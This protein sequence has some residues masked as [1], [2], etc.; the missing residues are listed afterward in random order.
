MWCNMCKY[1][2]EATRKGKCSQCGGQI[3]LTDRP[4]PDKPEGKGSG[5]PNGKTAMSRMVNWMK[6]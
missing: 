4:F 5:R 1:G 6:G 2:S 3:V